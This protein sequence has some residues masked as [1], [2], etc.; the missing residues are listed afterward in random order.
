MRLP[1]PE[2]FILL[3]TEYTAWEGSQ[4]RAWSGPG[5]FKEII[6]IGAIKV[7]GA[8]FASL[9]ECMA[10]V[11]PVHNPI[12]SPYI[13]K[14]TGITQ[15]TL[16]SK[17]V[18]LGEALQELALFCEGLPL[19]SFGNDKRTIEENCTLIGIPSPLST[20]PTK[21]VR[22]LF[23]SCGVDPKGYTSGTIVTR[24]GISPPDTVHDAL[25]DMRNLL[26]ALREL[27]RVCV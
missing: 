16:E 15:E 20:L 9:G 19:L 11:R 26:T 17:G 10:Y 27:G 4:E 7:D 6:Q 24:F 18:S 23:L 14:L 25:G 2:K 22:E 5:E 21:D 3:D 8:R 12:L 13:T 1:V